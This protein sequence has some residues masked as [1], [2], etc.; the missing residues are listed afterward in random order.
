M[1]LAARDAETSVDHPLLLSTR[2]GAPLRAPCAVSLTR[3]ERIA[4]D[5]H[6]YTDLGMAIAKLLGLIYAHAITTWKRH[7]ATIG[8]RLDREYLC[9]GSSHRALHAIE[10]LT[11][12]IGTESERAQ[13]LQHKL[14]EFMNYVIA[15]QMRWTPNGASAAAGQGPRAQSAAAQ[16][17]QAL[18]PAATVKR[19]SCS[20]GGV[21]P[22]M[23]RFP[24]CMTARR[25]PQRDVIT[26]HGRISV[27]F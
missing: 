18:A 17:L 20:H 9:H 8:S 16:G 10:E 2:A 5:M 21:A 22:G 23:D 25:E 26:R 27:F 3:L 15:K 6:G 1:I 12:D 24:H 4:V 14:E 13:V 11:W 7:V 19:R